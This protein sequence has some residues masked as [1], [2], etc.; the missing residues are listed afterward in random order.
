M[1]VNGLDLGLTMTDMR[2]MSPMRLYVILD[3]ANRMA[4]HRA[5]NDEKEEY[6][7]GDDAISYLNG[8]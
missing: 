8:L 6:L 7:D 5:G 3:E 2:A 4:R 1:L